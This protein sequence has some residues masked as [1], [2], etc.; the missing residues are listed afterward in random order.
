M[1]QI[2]KYALMIYVVAL[3]VASLQPLRPSGLHDSIFHQLLHFVCFGALVLLARG[4]FPGL[5]SLVWIVS[6]SIS[7]GATLEYL[8]H[9]EFHEAIERGDIGEDATGAAL[10]GLLCLYWLRRPTQQLKDQQR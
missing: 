9:W 2:Y 5:R 4:A 8:Q 1:T 6:A 7:L 3:T 10:S